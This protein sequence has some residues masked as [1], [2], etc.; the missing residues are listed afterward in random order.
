VEKVYQM[1]SLTKR[2]YYTFGRGPHVGSL[3]MHT[4]WQKLGKQTRL[5]DFKVDTTC[6]LELHVH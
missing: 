4:T 6:Q 1:H 3:Q 5:A 2:P